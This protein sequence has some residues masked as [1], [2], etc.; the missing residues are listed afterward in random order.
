MHEGGFEFYGLTGHPDRVAS[1]KV[2]KFCFDVGTRKTSS[3][4]QRK[5]Q[6][7]RHAVLGTVRAAVTT[8]FGDAMSN[9]SVAVLPT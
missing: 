5:I 9:V 6:T 1:F 8:H 4:L 7:L 2:L 3:A